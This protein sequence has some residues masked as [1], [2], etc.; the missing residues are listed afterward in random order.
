MSSRFGPPDRA[1]LT[2]SQIPEGGEDS[3]LRL[4]MLRARR[5]M[6]RLRWSAAGMATAFLVLALWLL[7][8]AP[9]GMRVSDY[10]ARTSSSLLLLAMVF[11]LTGGLAV[12]WA[13]FLHDEPLAELWAAMAGQSMSVRSAKRFMRRMG[14]QCARASGDRRYAFSLVLLR[15]NTV[16]GDPASGRALVDAAIPLVRGAVRGRDVIGDSGADELWMLLDATSA[17][18]GA[19][20]GRMRTNVLSQI[21][22]KDEIDV[23]VGYSEF[24]SD[25][26]DRETLFSTARRRLQ[27][28]L[29]EEDEHPPTQLKAG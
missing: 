17:D 21:H 28:K 2:G 7:P 24:G 6:W 26:R 4:A 19:I 15:L 5:Q 13:R 14:S 10:N 22:A 29:A 23:R 20:A 9:G 8:W 12:S 11:F 16:P 18:L 3:A 1:I 27:L 25:G